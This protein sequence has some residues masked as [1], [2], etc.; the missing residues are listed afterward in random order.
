MARGGPTDAGALRRTVL[1][2]SSAL[3]GVA[4]V[5]VVIAALP[6]ISRALGITEVRTTTRVSPKHESANTISRDAVDARSR[7]LFP[8]TDDDDV[9]GS[10]ELAV[11]RARTSVFAT[12]GRQRM[13]TVEP[14]TAVLIVGEKAGYYRVVVMDEEKRQAGWIEKK[15]V[16]VR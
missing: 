13:M 1:V 12:P 14:G 7:E 8:D 10:S 16:R 5:F 15:S 9:A 4:V 6:S 11:V 3:I 2:I